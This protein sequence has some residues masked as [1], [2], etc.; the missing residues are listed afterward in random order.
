MKIKRSSKFILRGN[1]ISVPNFTAIHPI[2]V[3]I[4]NRAK[5]KVNGSPKLLGFILWGP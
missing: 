3:D 5:G 4:F 2:A 1:R